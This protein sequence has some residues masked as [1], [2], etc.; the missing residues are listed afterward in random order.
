VLSLKSLHNSGSMM[1]CQNV[2][3]DVMWGEVE[4]DELVSRL[5]RMKIIQNFSSGVCR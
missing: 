1:V 4:E 5:Y 3:A 2:T